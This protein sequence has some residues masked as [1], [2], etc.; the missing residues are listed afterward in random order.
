MHAVGRV[1]VE[2]GAQ[3]LP[4]QPGD[5]AC[6]VGEQIAVP[7]VARP[8]HRAVA[9]LRRVPVHVHDADRERELARAEFRHQPLEFGLVV[10]PEA[11]PPVAQEIARDQRRRPGDLL[12]FLQTAHVIVAVA[13]EVEVE[14]VGRSSGGDPAVL[15]EDQRARVVDHG[16]AVARQQ[17]RLQVRPAVDLVERARRPLE[18]ARGPTAVAVAPGRAARLE[19]DAE[20]DGRE[21]VG[22]LRVA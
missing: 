15:I 7:G 10:D 21:A 16:I 2:R 20:R 17:P 6:R 19:R 4:M 22:V 11:A 14:V 12:E 1:Q 8:A 13:E 9:G 5:E 3:A 18:I